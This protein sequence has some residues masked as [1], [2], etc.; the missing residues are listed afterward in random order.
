M[1][2]LRRKV[3]KQ[4]F[5]SHTHDFDPVGCGFCKRA[6]DAILKAFEDALPKEFDTTSYGNTFDYTHG[7]A[8]GFNDCLEEIKSK[9]REKK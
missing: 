9:L 6:V 2:E 1:S 4:V 7:S 5:A 8:R 3:E